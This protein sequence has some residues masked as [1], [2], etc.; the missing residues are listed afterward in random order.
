MTNS[1]RR[2]TE[3]PSALVWGLAG[4]TQSGSGP[5]LDFSRGAIRVWS[6]YRQ[7]QVPP[8]NWGYGGGARF[9]TFRSRPEAEARKLGSST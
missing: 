9:R 4:V 1:N 6:P 3:R 8:E 7:A 5:G 2:N